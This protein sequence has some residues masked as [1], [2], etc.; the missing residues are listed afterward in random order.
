MKTK[1]PSILVVL[2]V[3]TFGVAVFSAGFY[4]RPKYDQR[5]ENAA[6]VVAS[7][8]VKN[9]TA[10]DNDA[11]YSLTSKNLQSKQTKEQFVVDMP[12]LKAD[13][14]EFV[15]P[16]VARLKGTILYTQSVNNLPPTTSGKTTG[17]FYIGVVK[18][19]GAW[20]VDT[21]SVR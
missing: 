7:K 3:V 12:G 19:D 10:G 13:K 6:A 1:L 14:P 8:F 15:A 2:A 9:L 11:A 20:K 17:D 21:A 16:Q 5:Q 4:A 18:E